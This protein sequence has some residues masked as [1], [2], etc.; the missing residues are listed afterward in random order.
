M[1]SGGPP[2]RRG[3]P[4]PPPPT[5]PPDPSTVPGSDPYRVRR[6]CSNIRARPNRM[7]GQEL[8][9]SGGHRRTWGRRTRPWQL[10]PATARAVQ[11][12][13]GTSKP[14]QPPRSWPSPVRRWT[15]S[16][17]A[18]PGP[19]PW[20][21]ST[22][23]SRP[24]RTS[25]GPGRTPWRRSSRARRP[26]DPISWRLPRCSRVDHCRLSTGRWRIWAGSSRRS[27][28]PWP[29]TPLRPWRTAA[30][31]NRCS[32]S[33]A[34]PAPSATPLTGWSGPCASRGR[35]RAGGSS[36]P[37][38]PSGRFP[39]SPDTSEARPSPSWPRRSDTVGSTLTP[40][41]SSPP[42]CRRPARTP[43]PA[44]PRRGSRRSGSRAARTC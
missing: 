37:G 24:H 16:L 21:L 15:S 14:C 11:T 23:W 41:T 9:I 30:S 6:P 40:W 12:T 29:V 20:A 33:P 32:A 25:D 43:R 28:R 31:E 17:T 5:D 22:G 35:R 44:A 26:T 8:L 19:P 7:L 18:C 39:S 36:G 38:R 2:P 42:P 13:D 27:T 3:W 34:A 10:Y 1:P 4:P